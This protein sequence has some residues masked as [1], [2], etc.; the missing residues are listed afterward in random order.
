MNRVLIW[1]LAAAA[2]VACKQ[3]SP[4][5]Q[6]TVTAEDLHIEIG[7]YGV[8]LGQTADL[9]E[10]RPGAG[11]ASPSDPKE[12]ARALRETVWGYNI[13]RSQLCRRDLYAEVT[14]GPVFDP[15]WMTEP[16]DATPSLAALEQRSQDVGQE[17]QKFWTAICEDAKRRAADP[18]QR[19]AICM[20][21]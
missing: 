14:C 10:G 21:E 12:L 13:Q 5:H 20:M 1:A 15:V 19:Q 8:M 6:S 11:M 18:S 17:V 16:P 3:N 2:L 4:A 7:R 9:T